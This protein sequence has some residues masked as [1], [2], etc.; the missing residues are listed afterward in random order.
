MLRTSTL[1]NNAQS[2][3]A[4]LPVAIALVV[5]ASIVLLINF[6]GATSVNRVASDFEAN[7]AHYIAQAGLQHALWQAQNSKCTG[8]VTIPTTALGSNNYNATSTGGG[9]STA[10]TLSVD[11]DAWIRSDDITI[12]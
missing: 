3:F 6:Q 1:L 12:K 8:D 4:L 5:V 9:T 2:G 10:Y 7:Q 11:Q